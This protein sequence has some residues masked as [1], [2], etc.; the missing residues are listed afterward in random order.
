[1]DFIHGLMGWNALFSLVLFGATLGLGW[2]A[3]R[4]SFET[5]ARALAARATADLAS[6]QAELEGLG[7]RVSHP[8]QQVAAITARLD[9]CESGTRRRRAGQRPAAAALEVEGKVLP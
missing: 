3:I 1:M 9:R 6:A 7:Q 2:L 5:T 8:E 4:T